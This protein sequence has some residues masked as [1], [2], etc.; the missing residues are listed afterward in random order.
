MH[1]VFFCWSLG[2]ATCLVFRFPECGPKPV[3][4]F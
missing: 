2:T 1:R 4:F 3:R